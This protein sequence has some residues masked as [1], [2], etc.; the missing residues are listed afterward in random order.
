MKPKL[1]FENEN[2]NNYCCFKFVI[3][4]TGLYLPHSCDAL[5][6]KRFPGAKICNIADAFLRYCFKKLGE[7]PPLATK[8]LVCSCNIRDVRAVVQVT[9]STSYSY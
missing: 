4:K 6:T 2:L 8:S 3:H 7:D 1:D 9:L 5:V